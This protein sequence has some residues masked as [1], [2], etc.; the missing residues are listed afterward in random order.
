[1]KKILA[2]TLMLSSA[3]LLL[4]CGNKKDDNKSNKDLVTLNDLIYE[5]N[6]VITTEK[7]YGDGREESFVIEKDGSNLKRTHYLVDD[8]IQIIYYTLENE[9]LTIIDEHM[10]GTTNYLEFIKREFV[11]DDVTYDI[12]SY[13]E[14]DSTYSMYGVK[15]DEF[16][17]SEDELHQYL[18]ENEEM[19]VTIKFENEK[20]KEFIKEINWVGEPDE[21]WGSNYK[22]IYTLGGASVTIPDNLL[23]WAN[24]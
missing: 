14:D 11:V 18:I 9:T 5:D 17:D 10:S 1:M 15:L 19:N 8:T 22:G 16:V 6:F 2:S 7:K 3:F 13:D 24:I 21:L 12:L 23:F 4:S 20:V